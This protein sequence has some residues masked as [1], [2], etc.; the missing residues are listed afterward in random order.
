MRRDC[1][2]WINFS[3]N[4]YIKN[5]FCKL[6]RILFCVAY[7][8]RTSFFKIISSRIFIF[9]WSTKLNMTNKSCNYKIYSIYSTNRRRLIF[10]KVKYKLFSFIFKRNIILQQGVLSIVMNSHH[11]LILTIFFSFEISILIELNI[12]FNLFTFDCY[13]IFAS[14]LN[15]SI[16]TCPLVSK[17]NKFSFWISSLRNQK[18][19]LSFFNW[20]Q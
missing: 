13:H 4:T 19:I 7:N 16:I 20:I 6:L 11:I 5:G 3:K 14:C 2:D 15:T 17:S 8:F 1:V 12:S 10:I 18:N 9:S